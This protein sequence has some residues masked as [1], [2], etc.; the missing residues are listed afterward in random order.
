MEDQTPRHSKKN[1]TGTMSFIDHLDELRI[2][3]IRFLIVL[4]LCVL[5]CYAFRKELLDLVRE[6]VDIPLKKYTSTATPQKSTPATNLISSL[7]SY[8]CSCQ[9]TNPMSI[10]PPEKKAPESKQ[11]QKNE[12]HVP[13]EQAAKPTLVEETS[14]QSPFSSLNAEKVWE[15][16]TAQ[17]ETWV[18]VFKETTNDFL[19]FFQVMMGK[20]PAPV[21]ETTRSG[22][23]IDTQ[24]KIASQPP[25]P[26]EVNLTCHCTRNSEEVSKPHSSMVFLSLPELFFTQMKVAIF[27]GFFLAFPYLLIELWGFA[28]PALYT[29]EKKIF[30]IFSISSYFFFIGGALFGYFIVF[31]Y[32]F[33]FFLSLTQMGEIMPSLSVGEYLSFAIKLLI[34]FGVIFEMPLVVFI[35]ARLGV[36]TPELMIRQ[37]RVSIV[38]VFI[39]SAV[40]T[41]PDPF[42]MI[43]MAVPLLLLYLLSIAVC[44]I[45]VNRKKASMRRQGIDIDDSDD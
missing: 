18:Q 38:V 22:D 35:L 28:G 42:T 5:A 13:V 31:P 1:K 8:N 24:N 6:P 15:W 26:G 29:D 7:N 39:V 16:T 43:L 11:F 36:I 17:V 9:E 44:F 3:L 2:R 12:T 21:F 45:A 34:A 41:P 14:D 20:D 25:M 32:G 10:V 23:G 37:A 27:A 4:A 40:L 19:M 33:D 30:W